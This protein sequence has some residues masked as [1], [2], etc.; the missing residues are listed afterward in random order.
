MPYLTEFIDGGRGVIRMGQGVVTGAEIIQALE[1]WPDDV[2]WTGRITHG[3]VDLTGVHVFEVSTE[4]VRRIADIE[5][6][7]A[8][9]MKR[10][11]V[12]IAAP[13]DLAFG[14]SRMYDGLIAPTGWVVNIVRS[15]GQ[16][17]AWLRSMVE[18]EL[19]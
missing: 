15:R 10:V 3:L 5:K 13:A 19:R 14:M 9:A 6:R 16:G 18:T 1:A 11:F 8:Q 17:V 2:E 12:A 7:H 4:E